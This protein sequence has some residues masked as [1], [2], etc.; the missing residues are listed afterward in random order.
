MPRQQLTQFL[1][2]PADSAEF[3]IYISTFEPYKITTYMAF[4]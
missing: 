2:I 3:E 1:L 4:K